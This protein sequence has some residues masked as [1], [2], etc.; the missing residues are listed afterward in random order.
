MVAAG[1]ASGKPSGP[2]FAA[3]SPPKRALKNPILRADALLQSERAPVSPPFRGGPCAEEGR[4]NRIDRSGDGRQAA[5]NRSTRRRRPNP[6]Q[7]GRRALGEPRAGHRPLPHRRGGLVLGAWLQIA[8]ALLVGV[9]LVLMLAFRVV[10][11]QVG[12]EI[13]AALFEP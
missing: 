2:A 11:D 8:A 13:S 9:P 7:M 5:R 6:R 12:R 10:L 1:I 3:L 4:P